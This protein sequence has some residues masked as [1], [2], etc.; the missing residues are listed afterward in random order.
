ME[1]RRA[2]RQR[3]LLLDIVRNSSGHLDA[4]EVYALARQRDASVSLSTVYRNL[5]LF[6][7]L[8]LVE[9]RHLGEEHHH[10][11]PK[12]STEHH[13]LVCLSCGQV[14]EFENSLIQQVAAQLQ[15]ETGFDISGVRLE[16]EGYCPACRQKARPFS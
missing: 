3:E 4:S 5:A 6:K 12:G 11:E 9:E 7:E 10:Y 8:G 2:T 1:K 14:V 16:L 15:G 13:H